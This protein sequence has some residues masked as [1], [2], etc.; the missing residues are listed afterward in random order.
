MG[1]SVIGQL[2]Q[3]VGKCS[4][5]D[6]AVNV[7]AAVLAE[8]MGNLHVMGRSASLRPEQGR[9]TNAEVDAN[10]KSIELHVRITMS[11]SLDQTL[12]NFFG[13]VGIGRDLVAHFDDGAPIL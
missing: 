11:Q 3:S 7:L 6:F 4:A 5:G 13:A 9:R 1:I 2:E 8:S 12:D 10:L